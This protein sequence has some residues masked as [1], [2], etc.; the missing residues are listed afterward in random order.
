[1][2]I[3]QHDRRRIRCRMLGH[4]INFSYCRQPGKDLPCRK[5]F[6]CWYETF[7]VEDFIRS[8]YTPE[9]LKQILT[10]PPPKM[11]SLIE[12]IQQARQNINKSSYQQ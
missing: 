12:L 3:D 5:I 11:A 7:A 1:M 4:E 6:D 2:G 9:Q 8:H 10:P